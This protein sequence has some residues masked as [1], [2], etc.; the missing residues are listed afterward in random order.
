MAARGQRE[1]RADPEAILEAARAIA[2]NEGWS[3]VTIRKIADALRYTSP[4]IYEHFANKEAALTE[5]LRRGFRDLEAALRRA[6]GSADD[7]TGRLV[8]MA[9][10]YWSFA[11]GQPEVY[12]IM[13]GMGGVAPDPRETAE[14]ARGVC[15][16]ALEAVRAWAA[17]AGVR[18][19]DPLEATELLWAALHG[20]ACLGLADRLGDGE[21]KSRR[22]ARRVVLD[23]LSGWRATRTPPRP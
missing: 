11:S 21:A 1:R 15:A 18:L 16:L 4:I 14:G 17:E 5:V 12:Q 9:E 3:A 8:A 6:G 7:P 13:H 2:R 19:D 22:M 23:L 20:V 10:A